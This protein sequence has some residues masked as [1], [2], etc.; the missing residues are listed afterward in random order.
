MVGNLASLRVF[1]ASHVFAVWDFMSLL[2]TLQRRLTCVEVPWLPSADPLAARL[3]NEIVLGEE[4]DEITPHRYMSHFDLYLEAMGEVGADTRP[5]E[6]FLARLRK[7]LS[8][9]QALTQLPIPDSAR[10]FVHDTLFMCGGP[11]LEVAAAFLLGRE[12][13]VPALF[14]SLIGELER[15]GMRCASFRLYLDRHVHL[16]EEM[17][18]PLARKLLTNLCGEDPENW[19]RAT[20]AARAALSSRRALWDGVVAAFRGP[21]RL[22]NHDLHHPS[23]PPAIQTQAETRARGGSWASGRTKLTGRGLRRS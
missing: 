10:R 11:T 8:F 21:C 14:R 1:M 7:G 18:A 17:H 5:L 3:I 20:A 22:V 13:L 19:A 16:D 23:P 15:S 4:T 6:Q 9:E 2:K 12:D